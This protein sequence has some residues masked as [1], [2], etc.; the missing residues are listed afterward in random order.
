MSKLKILEDVYWDHYAAREIPPNETFEEIRVDL[1]QEA[2][3]WI[4]RLKLEK[5]GNEEWN[6]LPMHFDEESHEAIIV[7]IKHFFNI[8]EEDLKD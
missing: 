5:E 8:T 4:K 3:K 2:I 1:K 6:F 7:W